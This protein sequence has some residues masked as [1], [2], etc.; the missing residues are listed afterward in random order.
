MYSKS[1]EKRYK[2]NMTEAASPPLTGGASTKE[3]MRSEEEMEEIK[4]NEQIVYDADAD[5]INLWRIGLG[6][7]SISSSSSCSSA[8][9]PPPK[10][11]RK[12]KIVRCT[13][14]SVLLVFQ[15]QFMCSLI[16][17]FL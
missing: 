7:R 13:G 1:E 3:I 2:P 10:N 5:F 6:L 8:P 14:S 15:S 4:D 9:T 12:R 17:S 11:V 16:G